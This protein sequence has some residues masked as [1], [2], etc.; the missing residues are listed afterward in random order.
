MAEQ[1]EGDPKEDNDRVI[2]RSSFEKDQFDILVFN[3][4]ES[5]GRDGGSF[6]LA[7][8]ALLKKELLNAKHKLQKSKYF[9]KTLPQQTLYTELLE[10][11]ESVVKKIDEFSKGKSKKDEFSVKTAE[12]PDF[13]PDD[14]ELFQAEVP[15]VEFRN[16]SLM[17]PEERERNQN[18]LAVL[19]EAD[20]I[21]N[22]CSDIISNLRGEGRTSQKS[23]TTSP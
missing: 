20:I 17:S 14:I 3:Y 11:I 7:E 1:L 23:D 12:L 4:R 15:K 10:R 13:D 16:P 5:E 22:D 18:I 8:D 19:G 21:I 9:F 6:Q 2:D